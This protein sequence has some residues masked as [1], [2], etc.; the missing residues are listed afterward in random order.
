MNRLGTHMVRTLT[1]MGMTDGIIATGNW[2]LYQIT[3][4][5]TGKEGILPLGLHGFLAAIVFIP[6]KQAEI[7]LTITCS[8]IRLF[9]FLSGPPENINYLVWLHDVKRLVPSRFFSPLIIF[10]L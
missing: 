7:S 8:L 9:I 3:V 1:V 10:K 4:P 2:L 6:A 5:G